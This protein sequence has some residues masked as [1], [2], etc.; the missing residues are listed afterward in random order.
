VRRAGLTLLALCVAGGLGWAPAAAGAG[1]GTSGFEQREV[2]VATQLV[3]DLGV[4]D[5]DGDDDLDVFTTNHN[6]REVLLANQGDATFRDRLSEVDLDQQP[7]FP[8]FDVPG[9]PPMPQNGVYLFRTPGNDAAEGALRVAVRAEPGEEVTGRIEFLF[10]VTVNRDDGAEVS[11]H[12]DTSQS[13]ARHAIEFTAQGNALIE[14]EPEQMAAPIAVAIDEDQPLSAVFV[15]ALRVRPPAHRFT[16][17]LRD[18]HGMAWADYNRDDRMDAFI[19]RG[20]LKGHVAELG[21]LIKDELMLGNG[22]TFADAIA[23]SGLIKGSCRGREASPVDYNRD[24]LLDLFWGCQASTPALFRQNG[25]GTFTN[26][27]RGLVRA[28]ISG[29]HFRWLDVNGDGREELLASRS[30]KL[31]VYGRSKKGKRWSKRDPTR[32]F[33]ESPGRVAVA[34]YDDDGDPDLFA[35]APTGN[36]LLVNRSGRFRARSPGRVGL[37]KRGSF[38]ASW[39]DYDNDGRTDL[40]V[41]PQGM[42]RRVGGRGFRP[43]GLAKAPAGTLDAL[44]TWSDLDGDGARDLLQAYADPGWRAVLLRNLEHENHWLQIE[45]GGPG[46]SYPA[47]GASVTV[48]SGERKQTQW[49]GQ[50]DGS[51]YS[52]GHYRLYFGLGE[53]DRADLVKVKWP[54]GSIQRVRDVPADQLLHVSFDGR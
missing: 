35:S 34:D 3:F 29:D 52:L 19:V 32:T 9:T 8:G 27:S 24:G 37:P 31:V 39:V 17:H 45:L 46:G 23:T 54:N 20:G 26:R 49:V 6:D 38:A 30:R 42:Y 53:A 13:P 4:V 10:P 7:E 41:T 1:P 12:F 15:G 21:G 14:L 16:L 18:R 40:H 50:N 36:T 25:D 5:F 44:A 28:R 47:A 33:G 11:T 51:R 43:T 2:D 48:R 22:S